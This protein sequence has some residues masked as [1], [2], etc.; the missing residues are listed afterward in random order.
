MQGDRSNSRRRS[1]ARY[2]LAPPSAISDPGV[3]P[4]LPFNNL[5]SVEL[6]P[7]ILH[8]KT[9]GIPEDTMLHL[10]SGLLT[11]ICTS[12]VRYSLT[13]VMY[14]VFFLLAL[15]Y[16]ILHSNRDPGSFPSQVNSPGSAE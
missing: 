8:Q 12:M 1:G 2:L 6:Y 10:F 14:P 15:F 3:S 4:Q 13:I 16:V 9:M 11:H 5:V 7:A